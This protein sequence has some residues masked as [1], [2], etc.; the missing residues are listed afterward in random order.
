M[1][2]ESYAGQGVRITGVVGGAGGVR[3]VV[4]DVQRLGLLCRQVAEELSEG[5]VALAVARAAGAVSAT[6]GLSPATA[7]VAQAALAPVAI[8][9]TSPLVVGLGASALGRDLVTAAAAYDLAERTATTLWDGV[10]ASRVAVRA[11]VALGQPE[12]VAA[13]VLDGYVAESVAAGEP[14]DPQEAFGRWAVDRGPA[15]E[16]DLNGAAV[17]AASFA[18]HD[19]ARRGQAPIGPHAEATAV[20]VDAHALADRWADGEPAITDQP[21]PPRVDPA[22]DSSLLAHTPAETPRGVADLLTGVAETNDAPDGAVAL[23]TITSTAPDG[24]ARRALVVDVPGTDAWS[25]PGAVDDRVRDLG[26]NVR[27]LGGEDSAYSRGVVAAVVDSGVPRDVPITLAG[28]SQGG[29]A[30]LVAATELRRRGYRVTHVVTAGAPIGSLRQPDGVTTLALDGDQDVVTK[31]DGRANR[32]QARR[33][34]VRFA[35]GLPD[36]AGNHALGTYVQAAREVDRA[37]PADPSLR[38]VVAQLREEGVLPQG[39]ATTSVRRVYVRR[40]LDGG[41]PGPLGGG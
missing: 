37:A 15:L 27:L 16:H 8:G 3:V 2:D 11:A 36:P 14:L 6:A 29:M 17:L 34:T 26:G 40:R 38:P 18:A 1:S 23:R 12:L 4:D 39:E 32:D 5:A 35:S 31:L 10:D 30:A 25:A 41:R 7:A 33:V 24:T 9:P 21:A 22:A 19:Q 28:H 13:G 20:G